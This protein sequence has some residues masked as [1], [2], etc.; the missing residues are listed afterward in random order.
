MLITYIRPNR[1]YQIY[2]MSGYLSGL[3]DLETIK[4]LEMGRAL[5][6]QLDEVY[7]RGFLEWTPQDRLAIRNHL[8]HLRSLDHLLGARCIWKFIKMDHR[9]EWGYPHTVL[10]CIVLP[11]QVL[12]EMSREVTQRRIRTLVH[13]QVHVLQRQYPR[14]FR[15]LYH[16]WGF[17]ELT[18]DIPEY[19][20]NQLL[21]NPDGRSR[22]WAIQ[23][24][25]KDA[26]HPKSIQWYLPLVLV[27]HQTVLGRVSNNDQGEIAELIPVNE[28]YLAQLPNRLQ[29]YHPNETSAHWIADQVMQ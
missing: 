9:L 27:N 12:Q 20:R 21:T 6:N 15:Q 29:P 24:P 16:S 2:Q 22:S 18:V 26:K 19:I 8:T 13:E 5:G 1:A 23:I 3:G 4:R 7:R 10:D 28:S 17:W 25:S 11:E 14:W